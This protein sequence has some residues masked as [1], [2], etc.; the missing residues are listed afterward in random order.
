MA[1]TLQTGDALLIKKIGK[2][3]NLYDIVWF[4][5]PLL[6]SAKAAPMFLQRCVAL[7]G[8]SFLIV[9]KLLYINRKLISDTFATKEN[10]FFKMDACYPDSE[11]LNRL[12][13]NEGGKISDEFDYSY[14]LTKQQADSLQKYAYLKK[15][16]RKIEKKGLSDETV[17]PYSIQLKWNMDNF[18][19]IYIP[20]KGDTLHLD[21]LNLAFYETLITTHESNQLRVKRDSIFI[22]ETY[23]STYICQQNYF[24]VMGD[25]RD[26]AYDSRN[27]GFLPQACIK[28][29]LI[30]VLSRKNN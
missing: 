30:K 2:T 16:E 13:L 3:P 25:N 18:G 10:Y 11:S 24:F 22:N 27:W 23:T 28:G 15:L 21:T 12:Q 5:Y 8:D 19:P 1:A 4:S 29:K 17:F 20:K 26:N 14:S 7:P 9:D 6:D